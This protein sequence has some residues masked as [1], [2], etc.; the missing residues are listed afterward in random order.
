VNISLLGLP[1]LNLSLANLP[2]LVDAGRL[3]SCDTLGQFNEATDASSLGHGVLSS[4]G[5]DA[6]DG[7]TWVLWA[8]VVLAVAEVAN[9]SLE[10]R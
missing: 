5:L 3:S 4:V 9:P 2:Q 1:L 8:A 6:D 7:N 10:R